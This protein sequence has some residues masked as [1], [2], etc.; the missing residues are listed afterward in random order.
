MNFRLLAAT[1]GTALVVTTGT[2]GAV[3]LNP[4]GLGQVLIYPYYTVNK[5][6]DTLLSVVNTSDLGKA[7]HVRFLEGYNG[8]PVLDFLVFLSPHDIWT[9]GVT[10]V[11]HSESGGAVLTT[12]DH[13]CTLP[14]IP[15]E[16]LPFLKAGYDGES[17]VSYGVPDGGPQTIE[18]TR[19]G[20][21]EI[22]TNGDIAPNSPTEEVIRHAQT[23][24]PGEGK[25]TGCEQL[26]LYAVWRDL[27]KPGNTLAGAAG[28]VNVGEGTYY[29]YNADA[30][31][32]FT[33]SKLTN[34]MS[35]LD[36]DGLR[37]ANSNTDDG[38]V[39]ATVF[40]DVGLVTLTY[41]RG[42]DA[43]SA[44]FMA[45]SVYNEVLLTTSLGAATDWILTF[46]TKRFY[47]DPVLE[48]DVPRQPFTHEFA[49]PGESALE[50]GYRLYDTE[51][52]QVSDTCGQSCGTPPP[53]TLPY[54]VNAVTFVRN[55]N[56]TPP[57][58]PATTSSVFGSRLV[59]SLMPNFPFWE[60]GWARLDLTL[61]EGQVLPDGVAN[62]TPVTLRGLPVTG[63]M[64]YNIVN[65]HA[66]PGKLA[67]YS[68]LFAHRS[69]VSCVA[70]GNG[71]TPDDP[72]S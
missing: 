40:T 15:A 47:V 19:E 60:S 42:I 70:S 24:I 38:R 33:R 30:L 43:V 31:S 68:G 35:V 17:Q 62:G 46:P 5:G 69:T 18:R 32:D 3:A 56:A 27:V 23:G 11:D 6:Q 16:G 52:L 54:E 64:A 2:A 37:W 63:F 26:E 7:L 10:A 67:N 48:P 28:I 9:A 44:V 25:P 41:Q 57:P 4:R 29:P 53:L 65:A 21:I 72:C 34:N 59:Q 22:V 45:E 14:T 49:A 58:V 61:G 55:D 51:E 50:I 8:R 12:S 1:I 71:Q 20:H 36:Y 66:Q 39:E 13:S